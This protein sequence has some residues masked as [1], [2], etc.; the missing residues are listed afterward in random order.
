MSPTTAADD[1]AASEHAWIGTLL[2]A[3]NRARRHSDSPFVGIATL[4]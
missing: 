1:P 2:P 4:S 3:E